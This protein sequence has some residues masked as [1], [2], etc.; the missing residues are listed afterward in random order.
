[1]KSEQT[2]CGEHIYAC[3]HLTSW[4]RFGK[5]LIK[6][7][8]ANY[9]LGLTELMSRQ[10]FKDS[11][12]VWELDD[13]AEIYHY[14]C[15]VDEIARAVKKEFPAGDYVECLLVLQKALEGYE[16]CLY[17]SQCYRLRFD[18]QQ[19][20]SDRNAYQKRLEDYVQTIHEQEE[21]LKNKED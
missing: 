19:F 14:V 6:H 10:E 4:F 11:V 3:K 12:K 7:D 15:C 17:I 5:Y 8:V 2:I 18:Y 20:L 16:K 9:L 1:M 13:K 21:K